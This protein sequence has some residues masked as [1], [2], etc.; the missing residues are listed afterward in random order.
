MAAP[1]HE[2]WVTVCGELNDVLMVMTF[3]TLASI[4]ADFHS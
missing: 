4:N 1:G 2:T 3:R